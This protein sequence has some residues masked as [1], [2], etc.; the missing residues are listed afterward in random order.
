MRKQFTGCKYHVDGKCPKDP[1]T[2]ICRI[3]GEEFPELQLAIIHVKQM[4]L[5][6]EDVKKPTRGPSSSPNSWIIS[7]SLL[8]RAGNMAEPVIE[9]KPFKPAPYCIE[10]PTNSSVGPK[11]NSVVNDKE[12]GAKTSSQINLEYGKSSSLSKNE[13]FILNAGSR[14]TDAAWLRIGKVYKN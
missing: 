8:A 6:Q 5:G 12:I 2:F 13:S 7:E 9:N 4:H 14:V 3:C 10:E 1:A 11:F